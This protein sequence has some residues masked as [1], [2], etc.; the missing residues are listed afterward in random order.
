VCQLRYIDDVSKNNNWLNDKQQFVIRKFRYYR[1]IILRNLRLADNPPKTNQSSFKQL[2]PGDLV[3]VL[4]GKEIKRTLNRL[5]KTGG[6]TFQAGMYDYC[7]QEFRVLK[8]VNH[9]FDETRMK[10]CKCNHI[11]LLEGA[12]CTGKTAYLRPCDR[13]CFF[14]WHS[15]WLEKR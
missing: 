14:F 4:P 10:M 3:R 2:R 5:N 15:A 7:G 13:N 11:Y 6:C 9:F 1:K 8:K 12:L